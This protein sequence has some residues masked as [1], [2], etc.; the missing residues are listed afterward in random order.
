[1][2]EEREHGVLE[3]VTMM[4]LVA[5]MLVADEM[6]ETLATSPT[7]TEDILLEVDERWDSLDLVLVQT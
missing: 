7:R 1:M 5:E 4:I 2:E 6:T 3:V